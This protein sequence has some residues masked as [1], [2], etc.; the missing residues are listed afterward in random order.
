MSKKRYKKGANRLVTMM[1]LAVRRAKSDHTNG[2]HRA[3]HAVFIADNCSENKNN[4]IYAYVCHLVAL[5]WYDTVD[6]LFGPVG[7]THN[8]VDAVHHVHNDKLG[9]MESAC[10][11]HYVQNYA[12]VWHTKVS[13]PDASVLD[14][15]LDWT[16]YYKDYKRPLSGFTKTDADELT[17]RGFRAV[18]DANGVVELRWKMDPALDKEWRGADGSAVSQGFR[19]LKGIPV[20]SPEVIAPNPKILCKPAYLKTL[21]NP[22]TNR[23]MTTHGMSDAIQYTYDCAKTGLVPVTKRLEEKA[24]C[25]EWGYKCTIGSSLARTGTVRMI[26]A[27]AFDGDPFKLPASMPA[28]EQ[29]AATSNKYHPSGDAVAHEQAPPPTPARGSA[30]AR[31][32]GIPPPQQ[33]GGTRGS[34]GGG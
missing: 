24:P 31:C 18:K 4:I 8:G 5:G 11:G 15:V 20:G 34:G 21:L 7:H 13:R 3:R 23:I 6:L 22:S 1:H 28:D 10:L 14:H 25:G 19:V 2:R 33:R 26:D 29:A 16:A 30:R 32:G 12:S 27:E 17:V 9:D